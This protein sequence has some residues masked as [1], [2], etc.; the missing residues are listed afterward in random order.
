MT[1]KYNIAISPALKKQYIAKPGRKAS[2]F[3]G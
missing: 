2:I 3:R 1:M